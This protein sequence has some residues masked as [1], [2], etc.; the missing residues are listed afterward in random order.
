MN[1]HDEIRILKTKISNIEM[2]PKSVIGGS[3][4][5]F[6][7]KTTYYTRSAEKQLKH[8]NDQLDKLLS[9]IDIDD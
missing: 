2:N 7:G 5:F 4:A 8:L 6:S 3:N 9:S 1:I